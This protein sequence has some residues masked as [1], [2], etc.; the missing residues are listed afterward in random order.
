MQLFKAS[1][2]SCVFGVLASSG[3]L[4]QT[5]APSSAPQPSPPAV[6]GP[7]FVLLPYEWPGSTDPHAADVTKALSA[8]LAAA[9]LNV[10]TVAPVDH[11]DAVANA[12]KLCADNG[13]TGI[14]VPEGRYEQTRKNIYAI[15][16]TVIRYPTHVEM[17]LDDVGC[18]GKV[19]WSTT[20]TGDEN[21]TGIISVGNTGAAVDAA[22]RTAA[23]A[24]ADA[25]GAANIGPAAPI[26][27][28]LPATAPST[29]AAPISTYLL[30]PVEEPTIAD[31]R[32]PDV[33]HSLL[34][35]LQKRSLNV[36]TGTA[37]DHV[38]TIATAPQ[39][40][41]ANGVQGIIV[42]G[43]RVEQSGY[44]GRSHAQMTLTL[45]SCSGAV[46]GHGVGEADMGSGMVNFGAAVVAVSERAMPVA[47]DRLFP[48]T[49]SP[50]PAPSASPGN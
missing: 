25:R 5:P 48:S 36:K 7:K 8:D 31:P 39:L 10:T 2:F 43:A 28:S 38:S 18:D 34:L 9:N 14:L 17:R 41:S 13:A 4:A 19:R 47:I 42:P 20:T 11:L 1:A 26:A 15:Y 29:P 21:P 27:A 12:A 46:L 44:S 40:C 30:L 6:A 45:L 49:A 35:A 16:V 22:F 37:I 3:A 32:G 33:T 23:K 24:A 50:T